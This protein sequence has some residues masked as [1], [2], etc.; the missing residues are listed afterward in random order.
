[1]LLL[2]AISGIWQ[3]LGFG[4]SGLAAMI[5]TAHTGMELKNGFTLSST[6]LRWFIVLM[7]AG[8]IITTILGIVMALTQGGNRKAAFYS[9]VLGVLFPAA[10]MTI[11]ALII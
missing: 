1:M 6:V 7:A 11:T 10:V 4:H 2:F 5:S 8:F 9:L 3:T